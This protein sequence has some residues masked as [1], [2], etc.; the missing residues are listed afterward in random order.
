MAT[1]TVSK[2]KTAAARES[3]TDLDRLL[4]TA[5]KAPGEQK[6]RKMRLFGEEWDVITTIDAY[7]QLG[8][9]NET[10]S[11]ASLKALI[12]GM[13][14]SADLRRW[15]AA[16][17]RTDFSQFVDD[18]DFEDDEATHEERSVAGMFKVVST[19]IEELGKDH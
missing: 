6:T 18:D 15:R 12:D 2:K 9:T 17:Q 8:L 19:L 10:L 4:G 1:S 7:T 3:I 14:P 13:V 5:T 11:E 16:W